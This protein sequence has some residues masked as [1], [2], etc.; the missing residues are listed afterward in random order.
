[1]ATQPGPAT[2]PLASDHPLFALIWNADGSLGLDMHWSIVAGATAVLA[3][4]VIWR[5][6]ASRGSL[7]NLFVAESEIGVGQVKF[8]L[9]PDYQDRQLAFAIWAE[10]A[11]REASLPFDP[12][13]DILPELYASWYEFFGRTRDLIKTIP[14]E[15]LDRQSTRDI[16]EATVSLL[17]DGMRPHLTKWG[18]HFR[19][20]YE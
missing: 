1:M 3:A 14:V 6:W 4:I 18:T 5:L 10:L 9:K 11:T 2:A 13:H 20:W 12:G 16:V 8:K 15:R 7:R 17:N 19:T